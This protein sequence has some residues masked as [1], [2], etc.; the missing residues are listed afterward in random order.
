MVRKVRSHP[1]ALL[2]RT[3][4]TLKEETSLQ[5]GDAIVVGVSGGGD[6]MALLH[7][8]SV[9]TP[10]F[11]YSLCAH[12]VDH[13]LRSEANAELDGAEQLA[14][15]LGVPFSRS[16]LGLKAGGNLQERAREGRYRALEATAESTGA[17]WIATAHH[18]QDRAETLLIRLL[19]GTGP[20]GLAVLPA[21]AAGRL[22]PFIRSERSA[23]ASH[24]QRHRLPFAEDPSNR[25]PHYLRTRVRHELLPL[26]E[27]LAEGATQRLN[28]LADEMS[29]PDSHPQLVR[30][31]EGNP[32]H[33]GPVHNAQ[34]RR[35]VAL[36][37]TDA[38]IW[39][40]GG[41]QLRL[42]PHTGQPCVH[43][44]LQAPNCRKNPK[45]PTEKPLAGGGNR[46]KSD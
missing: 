17:R 5:R 43:A 45:A 23:I 32:L 11:G 10:Q 12:G 1:P 37:Q 13:G 34:I 9:L 29:V 15:S 25:D 26:L 16:H 41:A 18:H 19:R 22:R 27:E 3:L 33:L 46:A 42:D 8:L 6:S 24:L 4:R 30:D 28:R 39:L 21:E 31:A 36:K 7:V 14:K 40:P 20:R 44:F 38:C 2:R 35:A